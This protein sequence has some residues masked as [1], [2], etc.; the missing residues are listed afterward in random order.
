[1]ITLLGAFKVELSGPH[2]LILAVRGV[3]SSHGLGCSLTPREPPFEFAC[4]EVPGSQ[5]GAD[6]RKQHC[7]CYV[8]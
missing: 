1:M 7:C 6:E 3:D 8:W 2:C 4:P 5:R